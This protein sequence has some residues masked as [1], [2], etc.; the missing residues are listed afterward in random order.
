M[1]VTPSTNDRR[2]GLFRPNPSRLHSVA[3]AIVVIAVLLS[4]AGCTSG[5]SSKPGPT[6]S[7]HPATTAAPRPV[8]PTRFTTGDEA[9]RAI[10]E[11]IPAGRHGDLIRYQAVANPPEGLEWYRM[12]Y[13][14]TT[15]SG[16]PTVETGI[17]T[18][19][20]EPVPPKGW[21]LAT[22]AHGSTGLADDCAPS[23]T[24]D[25]NRA[26]AAELMV[27]GA[28]AAKSGYVVASADYEGQGGPGR[29]PFLVGVSEG[30]SVLDAARAARRLPGLKFA[31]SESSGS[32]SRDTIA[33]VGYSQGGH[34]AL[35]ANQIA[36]E[37]TPEFQ[38]LGTVA[39]A[40]ASEI[41]ELLASGAPDGSV[42]DNPQALGVVAGL[43]ATDPGLRADLD[44]L[45]T[46]AGRKLLAAMDRSCTTPPGF[47]VA[48]PMLDADPRSTQPWQRL[49]AENTPGAVATPDPILI[50]HSE[51]DESV[52]IAQSETLLQ[53]MCA[54]GQV[55]ERRVLTEGGHVGA[56]VPAYAQGFAW[57]DGL[58]AGEKPR[59]SCPR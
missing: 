43:T 31:D 59:S 11:P 25:T 49:F 8:V 13:L 51:Q 6:P 26:S 56:A 47:E 45:V 3:V 37:W 32:T 40:P 18:V 38:V 5:H 39:G 14:S 21:K 22:H 35:W 16:E 29:H 57:L 48:G 15:V 34:A 17:V 20:D 30:R 50:I 52:P 10:P 41:A 24:I 53:R 44:K 58:A 23:R 4:V 55:V 19:P 9:F 33:I 1:S 7:A 36:S 12:M 42:V 28:D 27:V 54:A 46:P 2:V